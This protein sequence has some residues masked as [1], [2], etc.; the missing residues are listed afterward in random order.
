MLCNYFRMH[1]I[2]IKKALKKYKEYVNNKAKV[3]FILDL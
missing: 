3:L 1:K 2:G